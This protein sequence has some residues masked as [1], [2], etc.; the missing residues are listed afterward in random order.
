MT[1][2]EPTPTEPPPSKYRQG[3]PLPHRALE[4]A[5]VLAAWAAFLWLMSAQSLWAKGLGRL[6]PE[7][8]TPVY[9]RSTL[10]Q[11]FLQHVQLSGITMALVTVIG[12]GLGLWV[13][14][15]AGRACLPL[16]SNLTA[17][18]Q[19]FPPVAVLFLALPVVGFGPAGAIAA[20]TLYALL[21]VTRSTVLGLQNV[22]APVREA[23]LGLGL[24]PAQ[25][26]GW[27]ELPLA[28]PAILTGLRTALVLTI[29]TAT[30]APMVG[31]GGL[32]VPVIAGLG[33]GN[34]ALILQ[35]AVPVAL[36]ALLSDWTLRLLER[37]LTP[38]R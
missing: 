12:V 4:I 37:W 32:G 35:G 2:T 30:L 28:L 17:V 7:V 9:E 31:T 13:T 29:A 38:W 36:L 11:L 34:L 23:A 6:F 5:L 1:L 16:V 33:A 8:S 18:G 21:P 24:S 10:W 22:P 19:T 3:Q 15:P 20:L 26:L 27:L 14:R 25:Q